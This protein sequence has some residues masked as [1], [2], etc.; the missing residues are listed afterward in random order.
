VAVGAWQEPPC[1]PTENAG[2]AGHYIDSNL[3]FRPRVIRAQVPY[4]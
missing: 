3:G 2:R 1:Q 4:A